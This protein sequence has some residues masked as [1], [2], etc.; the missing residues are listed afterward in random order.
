MVGGVQSNEL[1]DLSYKYF[2]LSSGKV[3]GLLSHLIKINKEMQ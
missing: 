1:I 3:R 2:G